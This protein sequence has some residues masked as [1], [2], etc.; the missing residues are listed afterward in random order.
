M[1]QENKTVGNICKSN[2]PKPGMPFFSSTRERR[3]WGWTLIVVIAIYATLGLATT[4]TGLLRDRGLLGVAFGLGMLLV[5]TTIVAF[6]VRAR[7]GKVEIGVLLGVIATYLMVFL[8]MTIPEERSHLIEYG[9]VATF[10]FEAL[11][12]RASQ[13]RGVPVPALL[14]VAMTACLGAIDEGIQ[15][16]LPSRVFD[17]RDILFNA[18]AGLM[19]VAASI[20]LS[21]ARR[22]NNSTRS[23]NQTIR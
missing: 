14:A 19:A 17:L 10:I 3:L 20:V 2:D 11:K 6:A 9:V 5:G 22:R 1:P 21:W 13:A 15:L 4:L 23:Q 16:F 12:E 7:P 18:L 8:R